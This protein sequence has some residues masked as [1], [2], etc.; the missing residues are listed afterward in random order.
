MRG[1]EREAV[2][3]AKVLEFKGAETRGPGTTARLKQAELVAEWVPG[4]AAASRR[5]E[6]VHHS[7][8][9]SHLGQLSTGTSEGSRA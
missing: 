6:E 5:R 1:A 2:F 7:R 4:V 8:T 3:G 9:V